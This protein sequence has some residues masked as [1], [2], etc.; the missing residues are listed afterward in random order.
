[1][2]I[3]L[4]NIAFHGILLDA[5]FT[6]DSVDWQTVSDL[7][8]TGIKDGVVVPLQ[9][10]VFERDDIE[11]AFRFMAQGKHVG[12]VVVKVCFLVTYL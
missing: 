8:T 9:T 5:L 7:M 4:R 11:S 3:F 12:K 1:M 6:E 10:T 2:A